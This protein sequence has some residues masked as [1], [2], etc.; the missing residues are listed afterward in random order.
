MVG[1]EIRPRLRA[2][3]NRVHLYRAT[4]AKEQF[5]HEQF[6]DRSLMSTVVIHAK[7]F[8]NIMLSLDR[9]SLEP[10][11]QPIAN[12]SYLATGRSVQARKQW[13]IVLF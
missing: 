7:P 13:F 3:N 1:K 11:F 8:P 4:Q 12:L 10:R 9:K 6:K 5:M 2:G